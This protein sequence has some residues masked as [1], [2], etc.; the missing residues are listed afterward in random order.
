MLLAI[1]LRRDTEQFFYLSFRG[2]C[3]SLG[4]KHQIRSFLGMTNQ[5]VSRLKWVPMLLTTTEIRALRKFKKL[6]E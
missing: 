4:C 3:E 1:H 5:Q 2:N 6:K